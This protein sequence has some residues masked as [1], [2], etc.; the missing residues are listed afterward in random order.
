VPPIHF[1]VKNNTPLPAGLTLAN[2]KISGVPDAS[3]SFSFSLL[4]EDSNSSLRNTTEQSF[5]LDIASYGLEVSSSPAV[6]SGK[7]QEPFTIAFSA[8]GGEAPYKW[9]ALESLPRGLSLNASTGVL[10][11]KPSR[12]ENSVLNIR[13]TDSKG[14]PA[15]RSIPVSFTTDP[16]QISQIPPPPAMVGVEFLWQ[17]E[18]KGGVAPYKFTLAPGSLL[19]SGFYLSTYNPPGRILGKSKSEGPH[20]IKITVTDSLGQSA[21]QDFTLNLRPYD[22]AISDVAAPIEGK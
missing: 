19:P 18:A 11:G 7:V 4:A 21:E 16:L 12:P 2:G 9:S 13:V 3:G 5:T 6:I 15:T 20:A 22:L 1:A 8:T 17:L 10:S 14:F